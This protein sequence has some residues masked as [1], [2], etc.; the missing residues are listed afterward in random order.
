MNI[1]I[2][3]LN[4][5]DFFF[6]PDSTLIRMI[7]TYYIPDYVETI[8]ICP[9]IFLRTLKPGKSIQKRFVHRYING[10]SFGVLIKPILKKEIQ[11]EHSLFIANSLD[12]TSLIPNTFFG[13][14]EFGDKKVKL[15]ILHKNN[16]QTINN[17]ISELP[18]IEDLFEKISNISNFC[19]LRI[20]DFIGFELGAY[21]EVKIEDRF[22]LDINNE[23]IFDVEV[24]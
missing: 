18:N 10:Y 13:T 22:S 21:T 2:S 14:D 15:D 1:I 16:T 23:K 19:S 17:Q 12:Y 24:L 7:D 6:R 3:P 8:E 5:K 20:G 4:N 9:I 11:D